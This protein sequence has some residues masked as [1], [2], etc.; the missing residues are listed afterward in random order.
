MRTLLILVGMC[1][2][3]DL[4]STTQRCRR[5]TTACQYR[6]RVG[7]Y[8]PFP[9]ITAFTN[10]FDMDINMRIRPVEITYLTFYS[11]D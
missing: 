4:I 9:D 3:D 6:R 2:H 11:D 7:L 8:L 5:P 10:A 1:A